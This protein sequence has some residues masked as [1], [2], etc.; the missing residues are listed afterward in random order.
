M[1]VAGGNPTRFAALVA[2]RLRGHPLQYL[3]GTAAFGPLDLAVDDRVLIPRPETEQLWEMACRLVPHPRVVLD[4][5]TGSGALA[6]AFAHR[7]PA[8][9]VVAVDASP[10]A[11]EVASANGDRLGLAVEWL[12]GDLFDP[13]PAELEGAV[14]LLVS[15]PPYVAEAEWPDL[16]TD[17]RHEPRQ[18]LV[19]GPRGTEVLER[20]AA[21]AP[22]WL[23]PGGWLAC[24]IG[25]TQGGWA[26]EAFSAGL[27]DVEVRPDLTGR[28]RFVVGRRR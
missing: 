27:V 25:E 16:P 4:L 1:V 3:E 12:A 17:V 8:A 19:A 15:N 22:R 6:L 24:E 9:R 20:I 2:L 18:A 21:A 14:D 23:A 7:F 28:D 11:L 26:R 5:G 10:G 13:L